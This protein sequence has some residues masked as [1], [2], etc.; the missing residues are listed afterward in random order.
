MR[1]L[2][3][4][5]RNVGVWPIIFSTVIL[6]NGCATPCWRRLQATTYIYDIDV[7][8]GVCGKNQV[9]SYN[10]FR[11]KWIEDLPLSKCNGF[12]AMSPE[13]QQKVSACVQESITECKK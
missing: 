10:P 2:V 1:G 11:V 13:D 5:A 9:V 6:L 4:L 8:H 12:F 7:D 3:Y